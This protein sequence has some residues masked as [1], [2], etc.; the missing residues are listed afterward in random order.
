MKKLEKELSEAKKKKETLEE[1]WRTEKA[2]VGRLSELRKKVEQAKLELDQATTSANYARAAEIQYG[3]L[4]ELMRE[5]KT[6]EDRLAAGTG[7][8][9]LIKNEVDEEDIAAV[10][11]RWTGVPV[12]RLLEGE[13]QKLLSLGDELHKRVIGQDEAVLAVADAVV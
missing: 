6:E 7:K 8:P 4:P 12:S 1:Q 13:T 11:S 9:S 3:V 5:V 2:G 10:V